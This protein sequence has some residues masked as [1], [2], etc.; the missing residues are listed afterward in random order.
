MR[1]YIF[2]LGA[3]LLVGS[4]V[5]WHEAR[6]QGYSRLQI[7]LYILIAIP[8]A[9]GLGIVNGWL[10]NPEFYYGLEHSQFVL[11][12]GLVS[13]GALLGALLAG[14]ISS[15]LVREPMARGADSVALVLPLI[16][17]IIRIGCLLNGCCFG[18]EAAGFG[19]AYL[20]GRFGEWASRY[21]TQPAY[22]L[23]DFVLFSWL[24][25]GRKSKPYDGF[26]TVS[27]LFWFSLGRL[28]L[29]EYRELPEQALG[30]NFQQ[31]A[32]LATLV[33]MAIMVVILK[34]FG[35]SLSAKSA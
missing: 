12:G 6:R 8:L 28:I 9:M 26:L 1:S 10:F 2:F 29:D 25:L 24:W 4:L 15:R 11:R 33:C 27:F 22:M 3:A 16:L 17:G 30:M 21:A 18:R 31:L 19:T 23:F 35:R 7:A 14:A 13:F 34:V 32:S 5:G 20:P